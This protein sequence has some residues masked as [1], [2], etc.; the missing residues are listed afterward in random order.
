MSGS[1]YSFISRLTHRLALQYPVIA[2]LSFDIESAFAG[3]PV[4][5]EGNHVF[6]SGLARSG[7]TILTRYL[8]QTGCFASLTYREM[9]FVLMPATWRIISG[10]KAPGELNERTHQDGMM[11]NLDSPE[12]FEEV[13]WR[14]FCGKKYIKANGLLQHKIDAPTLKKF[15]QYV[16]NVM[17]VA[18]SPN[19]TRY[20]SKNN[21]NVLRLSYLT[22]AFPNA[23]II[24][25]FRH[26]LQHSASLL[27]QHL[28]FS[29]LQTREKFTLEYMNW[30]G[31]FE[32]GLNQK[33]FLF[34][35]EDTF[36]RMQHQ[37]KNGLDFWLLNWKNYYQYVLRQDS[38]SIIFFDYEKFCADPTA[39]L[40]RLWSKLNISSPT[41]VL[42]F[43]KNDK[44]PG[45]HDQN[46]LIDCLTIY[47]DLARKANI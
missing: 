15:E 33:S 42:P 12:A 34:E 9:P 31:H 40:A 32:F 25:P 4:D 10:R 1:N 19:R 37:P 23:S 3:K 5:S 39:T 35:N 43:Q 18:A 8:Y 24:I 47:Q 21:N 28:H 16:Y 36:Q 7:T 13:F 46:L 6:V 11:V 26:P 14:V 41:Q 30:L 2:E 38:P 17:A 29:G 45:N 20:L 22:G 44:T 27:Q